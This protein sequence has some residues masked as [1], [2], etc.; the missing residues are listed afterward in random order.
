MQ[1]QGFPRPRPS[2]AENAPH[3][4]DRPRIFRP[5][6]GV[7]RVRVVGAAG[8]F[9]EETLG[10]MWSPRRTKRSAVENAYRSWRGPLRW[11]EF[12]VWGLEELGIGT[13]VF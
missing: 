4:A 12:G 10:A 6:R 1:P 2:I 3:A 13:F 7:R 9:E 11:L 5:R 8:V